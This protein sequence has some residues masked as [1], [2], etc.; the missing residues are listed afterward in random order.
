MWGW[1]ND[2][3]LIFRRFPLNKNNR[4]NGPI[5]WKGISMWSSSG[6]SVSAYHYC[7]SLQQLCLCITSAE[8]VAW[9]FGQCGGPKWLPPQHVLLRVESEPFHCNYAHDM[10]RAR[11]YSLLYL[12]W[13]SQASSSCSVLFVSFDSAFSRCPK[14]HRYWAVLRHRARRASFLT[15]R[16]TNRDLH[17]VQHKP[18]TALTV[19][20]Q[21]NAQKCFCCVRSLD[22]KSNV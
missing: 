7:T 12:L 15:Q 10:H 18:C 13:E 22:D 1:V 9:T 20:I 21:S 2:T 14:V 5:K 16:M 8:P 4:W 6:G 19:V 3:I 11:V 17:D